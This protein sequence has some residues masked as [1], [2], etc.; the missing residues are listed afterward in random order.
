V[1]V[2]AP[3]PVVVVG[4]V[5]VDLKCFP[6]Y[7]INYKGRNPGR[8]QFYHGG[9]GRNVAETMAL[10]GSK[11]RFS[12]SVQEG[13]IGHEVLVRLNEAGVD[14]DGVLTTADPQGMGMWVAILHRDGDLACSISQMPN[15][16]YMEEAW[17]RHGRRMLKEAG[18]CVLELDLS[19]ALADQVL[20]DAAELG[21][22]VVG[23]PGNS[24]CIRKRPDLLST[25]HTY[26]CNQVE[27]EELWGKPVASIP[28]AEHAAMSILDRGPQQVVVTVGALGCVVAERGMGDPIHVPAMAVEVVDT[29]GAG[30]A[31][32]A[33]VSHALAC[34]ASLKLAAEAGT[35]VAAWTVSQHESVCREIPRLKKSDLWAGWRVL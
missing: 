15:T 20:R 18:L 25:L 2:A 5:F 29:T 16:A 28:A 14:V 23:L 10:L 1:T 6:Q 4:T 31:F 22:R 11:V 21:V 24:E 17:A 8:T 26:V 12:S 19:V 9:V 34:G 7:E 13:G 30:D 32:V 33:G 35:R 27:A 3:K